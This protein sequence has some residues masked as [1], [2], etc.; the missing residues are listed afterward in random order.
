MMAASWDFS[1]VV[2][3]AEHLAGSSETYLVAWKVSS[4]ADW[5]V[6]PRAGLRAVPKV[7]HSVAHLAVQTVAHWVVEMAVQMAVHS[8]EWTVDRKA[9]VSAVKLVALTVGNWDAKKVGP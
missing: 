1:Q 3:W 4:T 6:S 5:K 9:V 7:V 2:R 8:V